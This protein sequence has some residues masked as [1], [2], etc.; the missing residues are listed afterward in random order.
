MDEVNFGNVSK[1]WDEIDFTD[2]YL[3][4]VL[5]WETSPE[6]VLNSNIFFSSNMQESVQMLVS[7]KHGCGIDGVATNQYSCL[8][9]GHGNLRKM[10]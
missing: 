2:Y 10:N 1:D 8:I 5:T 9:R 3:S 4:E 6:C 7:K